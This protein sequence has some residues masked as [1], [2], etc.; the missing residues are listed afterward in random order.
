MSMIHLR[1]S[2]V[3]PDKDH[4]LPDGARELSENMRIDRLSRRPPGH[5]PDSQG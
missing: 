3:L 5:F 1:V 4:P 2:E